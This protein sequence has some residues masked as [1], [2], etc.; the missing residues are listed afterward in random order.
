METIR[1]NQVLDAM[2]QK[3]QDG[4]RKEFEIVFFTHGKGKESERIHLRRAVRCGL[5]T[6][7]RSKDY[8]I[9]IRVPINTG[10]D[11]PVHSKLITMFNGKTVTY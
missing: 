9:G 10:H 5:P 2:D 4:K 1:L 8:L 6:H 7:L 11:Y 3:G